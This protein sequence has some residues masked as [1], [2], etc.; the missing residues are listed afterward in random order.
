MN[1][2]YDKDA[3]SLKNGF[4]GDQ[5][6]FLQPVDKRIFNSKENFNQNN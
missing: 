3:A 4:K 6:Q 1:G 5:N 2:Y